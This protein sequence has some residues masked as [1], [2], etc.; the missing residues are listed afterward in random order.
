MRIESGDMKLLSFQFTYDDIASSG[1]VEMNYENLRILSLKEKEK[2]TMIDKLKTLLI[3]T[4][5]AKNKNENT[6]EENRK[7]TIEFTRDPKRSIFNYWWNSLFTGVKNCY[8]VGKA[9]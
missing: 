5:I 8:G 9:L 2:K 4:F 7:G 1:E 3:N 6:P